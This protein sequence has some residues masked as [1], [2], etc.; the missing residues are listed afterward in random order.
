MQLDP[1]TIKRI[2]QEL[3]DQADQD[4]SISSVRTRAF[5]HGVEAL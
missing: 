3:W 4:I 2:A 5:Q 1:E